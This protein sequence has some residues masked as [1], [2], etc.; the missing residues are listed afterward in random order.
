VQE[1]I[2][3]YTETGWEIPDELKDIQ[4]V[5]QYGYELTAIEL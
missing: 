4:F 1:M 3:S 5:Y 2:L